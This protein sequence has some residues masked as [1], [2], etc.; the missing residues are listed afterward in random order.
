[1]SDTLKTLKVVIEGDATPLK[2]TTDE[3]KKSVKDMANTINS[4]IAK[5]KNPFSKI[6][7]DSSMKQLQ[8]TK[9]LLKRTMQDLRSGALTGAMGDGIKDYVKQAQLAAGVKVHTEEYK[10]TEND[11]NRAEKA[12]ESLQQK[13]RDMSASGIK[14]DSKEYQKLE[15]Q[16]RSATK[17]KD[18]Y[19]A[20]Q[21]RMEYKGQDVEFAAP[22]RVGNAFQTVSAVGSRIQEGLQ[23]TIGRISGSKVAKGI[24]GIFSGLSAAAKKVMPVIKT[25][26]GAFAS[27]IH[28]FTS[29]I[30]GIKKTSNAMNGMGNMGHGLSGIFQTL[31]MTARFMFA[32]FVIQGSLNGAK[33]GMQNLAQYSGETN[34][35]LS[36]LMS[37]LTQLKNSLA[38]AFAP[39]LSVVTPI[40]NAL[41]QK[42]ISVVNAVGQ[43][44]ALLTGKTSFVQAKKVNQDYAA[45]LNNN[46]S[47]AKKANAANKDLQKTLLGF[48]QINKLDDHS[49]SGDDGSGDGAAGGLSPSDMFETVGINNKISDLASKIKEAWRNADF[50]EIGAMVGNKLNSALASIPWENIQNTLNRIAK[51]IAT[52]LNGFIEATDWNL[53]GDTISKGINTAFMFVNTFAQNF[54]WDSL[55]AAVGNGINGAMNGLDWN[56]IKETIRNVTSGIVESI[57]TLLDTADWKKVGNTVAEFFNSVLEFLYIA[58]TEFDWVK[59]GDSVADSINGLFATFDWAKAG[60]TVSNLVVGILDAL[61]HAV[62]NTDWQQVGQSITTCLEN[63]DWSGIASRLFELLGAALG[64]IGAFLGGLIGDAVA[65]AKDYFQEKVE[66][67]GGNVVLGILKGIG[68]ALANIGQWIVDN[69]F[70]PFIKGFKKAFGINSPSTVMKE[71]GGYI[72][73]GLLNGVTDKVGSV[74][75]WFKKLPNNVRDSMGDAK[76]WLVEKG[77]S[78]I[79]GIKNGY[80]AV[81]ESTLLSRVKNIKDETFNA[82][83]NVAAKVKSKG[84]DIISGIASGFDENKRNL[85]SVVSNIPSMIAS[86]IGSLWDIGKGAISSFADGFASIHIPLP[87]LD[88]GWNEWNVGKLSFSVPSFGLSWYANGGYPG[89]GEMFVARENGPELVGRMGNRNAVANNGQIIDGIAQGVKSAVMDAFMEAFMA[90]GDRGGSTKEPVINLTILADSETLYKVVLKG[91]KEHDG[92]FEAFVTI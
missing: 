68:D 29:G 58:V 69:V 35:S 32:S 30:P 39:I 45:S 70:S 56:L 34:Q 83:G 62:E 73:S 9:N 86:G 66:D 85:T 13:Q 74:L 67:C 55:G 27:L 44:M 37:S 78:A 54:H 89:T 10:Q 52:F 11:V 22:G 75:D 26:G 42:I 91:K 48:D 57:N 20:K 1:M 19:D 60:K 72:I 63:V 36:L 24:G 47:S 38:A 17:A 51:S 53:V 14:E 92:R 21:R 3:A 2:K 90:T 65:A 80:E 28:K 25:V 88:V 6:F 23:S 59:F 84:S 4:D 61:I 41:I 40:L 43:L 16:I 49:D 82:V 5:V 7:S 76:T 77:K 64:G 33:E 87:H 50:T 15:E 81:K 8:N 79:E 31:G 12:L 18:A 46:T 71:Q